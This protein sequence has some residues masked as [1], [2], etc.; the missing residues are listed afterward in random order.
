MKA[1]TLTT[2]AAL[3]SL[4]LASFEFR[5]RPELAIPHLNITTRGKPEA[6]EKGLLFVCQYP[7]FTTGPDNIAFGPTQP[8]AY[9]FQDDGELVWS[10]VGYFGGWAANVAP[11]T[12][13]GEQYLRGFQGVLDPKHGRMFGF[14]S[15]LDKHYQHAK[16]VQPG[17]H[18]WA[19]A[20]EFNIIDERTALI[21]ITV[22]IPISLEPWGGDRDQVWILSSG[23]QEIDIETGNLVFE[24]HSFE[25]VDPKRSAIPLSTGAFGFG[26]TESDAWDYFHLNSAD[27]DDEGNYLISAR[28]TASVYKIN[29]TNG[30]VI[31]Q[32]GGLRGG[33]DFEF[34]DPENDLFG[35]QHHARFRGRSGD[36][37]I[38]WI[39][40]FDN[41]AHSPDV[42]THPSSRG[43]VYTLSH[44]TGKATATRSYSAP[45]GL[46]ASSQGST[47]ILPNSNVFVN[48]GQA[49]AI[50]EFGEDGEV[51]FHAYLDSAPAGHL[52]Q[53][54][55]G[56]RANWT[57]IPAEEPALVAIESLGDKNGLDI[58]VSWNGDT[59]TKAWRF[60]LELGNRLLGTTERT[61]FETHAHFANAVPH[62]LPG[63]VR[64]YAEAVGF[65]DKVLRQ[66]KSVSV[67]LRGKSEEYHALEAVGQN[68]L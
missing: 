45:D 23:F 41:G 50:T 37:S 34:E 62:E 1:A 30:Q 12:W 58:F 63:T 5:S 24:W 42:K 68:E 8:S 35:Y 10:G 15:L 60:Y 52:V 16:V 9:I 67:L 28:N 39:S 65:D 29:G 51:L 4:A 43:R 33:S 25:H 55:R 22:T 47:Q 11:V 3:V 14:H 13:N 18:R 44:E 32:L 21:E 20:H 7:G 53:S 54:Y 40:L 64:V 17:A 38:E 6:L 61:G 57:G 48:W 66:A 27:K 2:F 46:S 36:G 19:S 59:E 26:R 56:F 31:W 49:G